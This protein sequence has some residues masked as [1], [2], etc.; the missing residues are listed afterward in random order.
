MR[1][2]IKTVLISG[3]MVLMAYIFYIYYLKPTNTQVVQAALAYD[4]Q[5]GSTQNSASTNGPI[6]PFFA[7]AVQFWNAS[8]VN[9]SNEYGIDKNLIATV[10]Q[11]ESCGNPQV[12]SSAGAMGLF[13]VMPFHFNAYENPYDPETNALRGLSYLSRSLGNAGGDVRLALAG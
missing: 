12:A 10:M 13:Q 2:L 9:W 6:A 5:T 4:V 1:S 7:P 11:I 8:I 3:C